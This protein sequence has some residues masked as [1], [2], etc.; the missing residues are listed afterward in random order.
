VPIQFD[1]GATGFLIGNKLYQ[2]LKSNCEIIDLNVKGKG[3]G[4]G[5]EFETKYFR[6][7][8]I[9]IGDYLIKNVVAYVPLNKDINDILLGIGVL[10]KFKEVL[11]SLNSKKMRFYK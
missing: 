7:K 3:G 1:S 11:W 5:S 8:E 10:K 9:K 4:V 2:D 6:I